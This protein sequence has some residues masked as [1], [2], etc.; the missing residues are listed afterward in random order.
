[1]LA[2]PDRVLADRV[3]SQAEGRLGTTA[4]VEFE[5]SLYKVRLGRFVS[6]GEAEGLR[7]RAI[8]MGYT[9]AFRVKILSA[10]TDE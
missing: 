1:V 4:R 3:A 9:G 10:T 2:T 8:E 7:D 5:G 6:E